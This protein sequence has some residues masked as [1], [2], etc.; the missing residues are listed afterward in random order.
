LRPKKR[1]AGGMPLSAPSFIAT[2]T[3]RAQIGGAS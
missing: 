1:D 3:W 2:S